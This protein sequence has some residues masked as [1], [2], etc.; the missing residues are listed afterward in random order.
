MGLIREEVLRLKGYSL[1]RPPH[2][3]KL[4]QN[5]SP[6]DLP[7]ALKEKILGRLRELSW[8]RYPT[9]FCD[10]LRQKVAAREGWDPEGVLVTGGSNV[11]IQAIVVAA[12]V[13]GR[14]LTVTPGFS[15]YGIEGALL[16][17]RVLAVRLNRD[18]FSLPA[19]SFVKQLKRFH[20]GVVF[21]ANPNAPSGNLFPGEAL[22][23]ILKVSK[24]QG[25]LVVVDEAYFP[26][27]R[28]TLMPHLQKFPNLILL[29]TFSKA[30]SLGG[31]RLGYLLAAPRIAREVRKA[32]L[33]FS[34]G[35]LS[36]AVGEAVLEDDSYIGPLVA[37]IIRERDSLYEEMKKIPGLTVYPSAAN[38]ILFRS[39]RAKGIFSGLLDAGILIRD[40]SSRDLPNALR[41]TVGRPDENRA[42]LEAMRQIAS[43]A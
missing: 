40:V 39:P 21:L 9:P 10:P 29:R 28:F 6:F 31:V 20:P 23:E 1:S 41:V 8:N 22:L 26:F 17:N 12:A 25:T 3:I 13:K 14:I 27:S 37:G 30:F 43:L 33:P 38:F 32:V 18:D 35:L 36:Q 7:A 2:R 34:V 19:G 24:G 42:F 16:G 15:L 4:N 5:E 11:L